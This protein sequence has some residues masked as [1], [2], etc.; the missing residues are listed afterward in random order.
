M[1]KSTLRQKV[2]NEE[3]KNTPIYQSKGIPVQDYRDLGTWKEIRRML[4]NE[5]NNN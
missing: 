5:E 2:D 3:I 4:L 1:E